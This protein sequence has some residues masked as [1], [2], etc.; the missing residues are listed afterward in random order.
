MDL[1]QSYE[2]KADD[3]K[4]GKVGAKIKLWTGGWFTSYEP[5]DVAE[6]AARCGAESIR[7]VQRNTTRP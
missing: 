6:A 3:L 4:S 5:G 7:L 1:S 2:R